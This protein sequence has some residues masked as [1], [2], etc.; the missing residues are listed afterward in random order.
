[1]KIPC[2]GCLV[3]PVCRHK[4]YEDIIFSCELVADYLTVER[5]KENLTLRQAKACYKQHRRRAQV[6]EETLKPSKWRLG[7]SQEGAGWKIDWID[8]E[9]DDDGKVHWGST[10]F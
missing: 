4:Y 6:V 9:R 10:F 2:R 8:K 3:L 7:I 1:M 5:H